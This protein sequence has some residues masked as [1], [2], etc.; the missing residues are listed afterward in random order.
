MK[1]FTFWFIILLCVV[2]LN[3]GMTIERKFGE[4]IRA[5]RMYDKGF[6]AGKSDGFQEGYK[7][8]WVTTGMS[9]IDPHQRF[10]GFSEEYGNIHNTP[11]DKFALEEKVVIAM[12]G[13]SGSKLNENEIK[14]FEERYGA[15]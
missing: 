4:N 2:V 6:T 9:W 15:K 5:E 12:Y 3:V 13:G 14:E 1:I 10:L 8:C 7:S 11:W